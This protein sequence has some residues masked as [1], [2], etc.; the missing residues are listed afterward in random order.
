MTCHQMSFGMDRGSRLLPFQVSGSD[1]IWRL[2][3]IARSLEL[4]TSASWTVAISIKEN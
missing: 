3:E 4:G 2:N 1:R